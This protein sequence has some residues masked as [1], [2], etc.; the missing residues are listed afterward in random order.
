MK[1]TAYRHYNY[2]SVDSGHIRSSIGNNSR[3]VEDNALCILNYIIDQVNINFLLQCYTAKLSGK[4]QLQFINESVRKS[5]CLGWR[6]TTVFTTTAFQKE[7][8]REGK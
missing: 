1:Y 8:V 4:K 2:I 6:N 5:L 7:I 3:P